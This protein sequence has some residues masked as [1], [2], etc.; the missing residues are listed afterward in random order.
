[1]CPISTIWASQLSILGRLARSLHSNLFPVRQPRFAG[2][3]NGSFPVGSVTRRCTDAACRLLSHPAP[4]VLGDA[5]GGRPGEGDFPGG[6]AM[7]EEGSPQFTARYV[8]SF[9]DFKALVATVR[10]RRLGRQDRQES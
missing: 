4:G 6:G 3:R 2:S 1:M 7:Q 5:A 9:G 10:A 8:Y